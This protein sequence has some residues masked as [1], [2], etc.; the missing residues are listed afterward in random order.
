MRSFFIYISF[1]FL[2]DRLLCRVHGILYSSSFWHF[3]LFIT[4]YFVPHLKRR[5]GERVINHISFV[6]ISCA[7]KNNN[8]LMPKCCRKIKSSYWVKHRHHYMHGASH[9]H[10]PRLASGCRGFTNISYFIILLLLFLFIAVY[11]A[12][13][14]HGECCP[15]HWC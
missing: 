8:A 4:F 2:H 5:H 7:W 13:S 9:S 12:H 14:F 11:F 10:T 3:Y 1:F 15:V 6:T